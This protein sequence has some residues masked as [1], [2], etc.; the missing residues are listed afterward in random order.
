[1]E[2]VRA[3]FGDKYSPL[4]EYVNNET[5]IW[6][7]CHV[8][9]KDFQ[10]MPSKLMTTVTPEGCYHCSKKN[11]HKT[12]ESFRAEVEARYPGEYDIIGDYVKAQLQILVRHKA[13]GHVYSVTPDN[14]LRG[15]RCP[16]CSGRYS[17]YMQ[18]V[19]EILLQ[20]DIRF[21]HEKRYTDCVYKRVLPFDFYLPDYNMCIEVDGEFHFRPM[22]GEKS[23]EECRK[24]DQIK[25]EYCQSHGIRLLRLSYTDQNRYEYIILSELHANTEVSA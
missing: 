2:R 4:E 7:H 16:F 12:P 5:K 24:R 19:E 6:M 18:T 14:L 11:K 20:H 9:G 1:M 23:L 8:C 15:K 17:S 25:T 22:Y 10:K 13:C 21:V 3:N